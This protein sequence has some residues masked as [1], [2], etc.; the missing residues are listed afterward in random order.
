MSVS[1][2]QKEEIMS[3]TYK[4]SCCRRALLCGILFA[5]AGFD[6]KKITLSLSKSEYAEF[7]AKLIA[8]FYGKSEIYRPSGGGRSICISF[9]SPAV[10]KYLSDIDSMEE[11]DMR[12]VFPR[13]CQNCLCAFL[14]GVFFAS[15][16]LSDPKKQ[17]ALEFSLGERTEVFSELLGCLSMNALISNKKS[18]KVLYFRRGDDIEEFYGHAGLNNVVFDVIEQKITSLARRESQ[19]YLNCVTR[20]YDRMAAVSER[21]ISIISKLEKHQLLSSLPEE[22]EETARLKLKYPDLPLSALA[23]QMVPAISKSGLSHRL[24]KIEEVCAKLLKLTDE[25]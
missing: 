9:D 8:E 21:Q 18:G 19:R 5:K 12:T 6:G 20:N 3:Y 22:L 7:T 11:F 16:R 14:R 15:G 10:A 25:I 24:K 13:K 23:S 17:Y 4:S 1:L 2:E